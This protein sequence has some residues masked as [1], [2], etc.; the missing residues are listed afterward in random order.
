MK[1]RENIKVKMGDRIAWA[2]YPN[3]YLPRKV[4][5]N[6][7]KE[8]PNPKYLDILRH[9]EMH[10]KRQKKMGTLKWLVKYIFSPKFRFNE[11]I[12]AIKAQKKFDLEKSAK[13]LSGWL[14]FWP[15]SYNTAKKEL[16]KI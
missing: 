1:L 15:V 5:E 11:E 14:Y 13:S 3:I 10:I 4:F 16:E 8:K 6:L 9:E 2:I 7:K 12:K